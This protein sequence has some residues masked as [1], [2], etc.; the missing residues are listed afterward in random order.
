[1]RDAMPELPAALEARIEATYG[2]P[3]YDARV[4]SATRPLA[5]YY[6]ETATAAGDGKLAS[7]WVMTEV[8]RL[9]KD[10]ADGNPWSLPFAPADLG[11]MLKLIS[12]GSISGKIGKIVFEEMAAGG[13]PP[14]T[15]IE[16][17]GL[18]QISDDSAIDTLVEEVLKAHPGPVDE[19]LKGKDA[20]FQFLIGQVMKTSK[21]RANPNKLRERLQA[22]LDRRRP[23]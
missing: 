15:I 23:A 16:K 18:V 5:R 7:N 20:T 9:V 13:G 2:I 6:E 10:D 19:Y 22:A 1:V 3:G 14:E 17:K 11:R 21:G 12:S 4:L 8:M